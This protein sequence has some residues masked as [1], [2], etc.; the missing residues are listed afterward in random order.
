MRGEDGGRLPI[1]GVRTKVYEGGF[2]REGGMNGLDV[3]PYGGFTVEVIG[4][5]GKVSVD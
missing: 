2:S 1:V 4:L 3:R 5:A